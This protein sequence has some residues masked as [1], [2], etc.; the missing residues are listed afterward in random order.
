QRCMGV[1]PQ[2][3]IQVSAWRFALLLGAAFLPVPKPIRSTGTLLPGKFPI[4][5]RLVS[6]LLAIGCYLGAVFV[7]DLGLDQL[8][9]LPGLRKLVRLGLNGRSRR[10]LAPGFT[11]RQ[12]E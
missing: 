6:S 12:P 2:Q 3:A 10:Y 8:E 4:L 5:K 11:P 9:R 1:C 7:I